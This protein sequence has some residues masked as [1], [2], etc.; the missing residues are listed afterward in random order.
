VFVWVCRE[1]LPWQDLG[2]YLT[3]V[4]VLDIPA[5]HCFDEELR[6]FIRAKKQLDS[7]P[8]DPA[9]ILERGDGGI[10]KSDR[11]RQRL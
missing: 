2:Q 9:L 3:S 8:H 7:L 11:V 10:G 5:P 1:T 4:R 6:M